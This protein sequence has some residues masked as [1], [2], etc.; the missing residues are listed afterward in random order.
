VKGDE[1]GTSRAVRGSR[2]GKGGELVQV[3]DTSLLLWTAPCLEGRS[4]YVRRSQG[5]GHNRGRGEV[6]VE[7]SEAEAGLFC[8]LFISTSLYFFY[9]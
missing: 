8:C 2:E 5:S 1:T 6:K 3:N 9:C 4:D 7:Q